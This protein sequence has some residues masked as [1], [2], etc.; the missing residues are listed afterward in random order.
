MKHNAAN[1]SRSANHICATTASVN[2]SHARP[3]LR[4]R[5]WSLTN[6]K[7]ESSLHRRSGAGLRLPHWSC[8][9][10]SA[11]HERCGVRSPNAAMRDHNQYLVTAIC[12]SFT[13]PQVKGDSLEGLITVGTN[14][15]DVVEGS[16]DASSKVTCGAYRSDTTTRKPTT[17]PLPQVRRP[18]WLVAHSPHRRIATCASSSDGDCASSHW[19]FVPADARA[20]M[21]TQGSGADDRRGTSAHINCKLCIV[22]CSR[23]RF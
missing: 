3:N 17:S 11:A 8:R 7:C 9:T 18:R 1:R 13:D 21:K 12:G 5:H 6:D 22:N 15:D 10:G 19:S 2:A 14:L 23:I 4:R 20:Q 16:G